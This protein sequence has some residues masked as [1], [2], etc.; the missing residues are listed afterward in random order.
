MCFIA[1]SINSTVIF[2]MKFSLCTDL[3]VRCDYATRMSHILYNPNKELKFNFKFRSEHLTRGK[4]Q[5]TTINTDSSQSRNS[6]RR[7]FLIRRAVDVSVARVTSK[8]SRQNLQFPS[9]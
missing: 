5:V 3:K 9:F 7:H 8:T 6:T 4:F 1:I 2:T